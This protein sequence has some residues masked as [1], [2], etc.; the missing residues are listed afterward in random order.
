MNRILAS[1]AAFAQAK[2]P[3][4]AK[5]R[6]MTPDKVQGVVIEAPKCP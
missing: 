4:D 2:P 3:C 6:V 5:G 1:P